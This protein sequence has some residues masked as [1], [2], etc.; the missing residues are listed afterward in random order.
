MR[1]ALLEWATRITGMVSPR[2]WW[3]QYFGKAPDEVT[4]G[5]TGFH[6]DWTSW[7]QEVNGTTEGKISSVV[8]V[9]LTPC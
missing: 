9:L 7:S 6:Q 5:Y 8:V 1:R 4:G 2:V 3:V